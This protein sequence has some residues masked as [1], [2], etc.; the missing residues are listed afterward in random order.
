MPRISE[1]TL[2]QINRQIDVLDTLQSQVADI[3]TKTDFV[4]QQ[5]AVAD[6]FTRFLQPIISI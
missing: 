6:P 4:S 5:V 3:Q 1:L 2:N